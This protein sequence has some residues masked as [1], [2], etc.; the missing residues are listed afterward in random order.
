MEA[1]LWAS[2][3][4]QSRVQLIKHFHQ[5]P[6]TRVALQER[7][8]VICWNCRTC[9]CSGLV[10]TMIHSTLSA[11]SLVVHFC[12]W[13]CFLS[14][15][16]RVLYPLAIIYRRGSSTPDLCPQPYVSTAPAVCLPGIRSP[17]CSQAAARH[18]RQLILSAEAELHP[19]R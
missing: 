18:S 16:S 19:P 8:I 11:Y 6:F 4:I 13:H 15:A 9:P 2:V 7:C 14:F 5:V 3:G 12:P 10:F 17:F 1:I